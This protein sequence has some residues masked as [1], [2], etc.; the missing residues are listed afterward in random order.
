MLIRHPRQTARDLE[1]WAR[2]E[3]E[4]AIN[5][6]LPRMQRLEDQALA[7]LEAF[8]AAGPCWVGTSWGKE[9][10]IVAHLAARLPHLSIPVV[11]FRAEPNANPDCYTVRDVFLSRWPVD[12]REVVCR[13]P[14]IGGRWGIDE[15]YDPQWEAWHVDHPRHVLGLRAEENTTRALRMKRWGTSTANTCAPIGFWRAADVYA[16]LHKHDLPIHPAYACSVGGMLERAR[17]R[18]AALGGE[19]GTGHGRAEWERRYYGRELDTAALMA[20]KK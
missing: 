17:L 6:S 19:E 14:L 8:A 4:D 2:W 16:Y 3:R 15:G 9:S 20:E 18:V 5:A 12:Y 1:A 10:I 11:W 13:I 7:D